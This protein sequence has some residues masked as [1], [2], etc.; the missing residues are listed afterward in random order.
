MIP[1]LFG[2]S[3][4]GVGVIGMLL[5]FL[6]AYLVS[7]ATPPPPEH[8]QHLVEEVRIPKGAGEAAEH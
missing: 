6:V 1:N 5:N 7:R 3:A 2:I 4:E 8:I